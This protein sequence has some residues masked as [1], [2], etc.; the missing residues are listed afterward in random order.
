M[1]NLI[2]GSWWDGE[3]GEPIKGLVGEWGVGKW[4]FQMTVRAI[5]S[6]GKIGG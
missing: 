4:G 1:T 2:R 6:G 5:M 3:L